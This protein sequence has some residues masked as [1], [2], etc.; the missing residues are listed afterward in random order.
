M[1]A[2]R[3]NELYAGQIFDLPTQRA[4]K[5][6]IHWI[7]RQAQGEKILDIGCSQGIVCLLLGREGFN[8]IGVDCEQD[9]INFA[10]KELEKE[11]SFVRQRVKF[12][13]ADASKLP[14]E[15][16]FFDT[17][18]LGEILEHLTHPEKVLQEARR[19]LKEGGKAI[20]T[21]PFGLNPADDHKRIYYPRSFLETVRPYFRMQLID[22]LNDNI[23][24]CGSKD[25]SYDISKVSRET[26]LL[27]DLKM[28]EKVEER[29][30]TKE[31]TLFEKANI[32]YAQ[33]ETLEEKINSLTDTNR[34]SKL[35]LEDKESKEA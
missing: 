23:I 20:I 11:E 6:R 2:D 17:V 21:I 12:Q 29:C 32:L 27:E 3:I 9:A 13:L 15:D 30:L 10:L 7:C 31:Q 19:L 18:I 8:C 1:N 14:F 22:T 4:A 5:E 25:A 35:A 24:Y 28:Q 34:K 26:L 33:I 16:N